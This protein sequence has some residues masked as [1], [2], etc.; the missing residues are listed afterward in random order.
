MTS[1]SL[2]NG[3][4]VSALS[5]D[6]TWASIDDSP[7]RLRAVGQFRYP[8]VLTYEITTIV[9]ICECQYRID[10]FKKIGH[11]KFLTNENFK[12]EILYQHT[13]SLNFIPKKRVH[14]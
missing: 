10:I 1:T 6:C 4:D 7:E 2:L 13:F 3:N 12:N 9:I 8:I 5:R 11:H 14:S